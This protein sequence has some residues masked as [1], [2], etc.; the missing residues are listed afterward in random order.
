MSG[1]ALPLNAPDRSKLRELS[2]LRDSMAGFSYPGVGKHRR[3][4]GLWVSVCL[5]TRLPVRT[6]IA[7]YNSKLQALLTCFRTKQGAAAIF[8]GPGRNRRE[9]SGR[10]VAG[11]GMGAD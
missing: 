3:K 7:A 10:L 11:A 4:T 6:A 9:Y 1:T 2:Y 8:V 5:A